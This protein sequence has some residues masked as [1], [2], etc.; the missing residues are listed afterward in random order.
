MESALFKRGDVTETLTVQTAQMKKAVVRTL[1]IDSCVTWLRRR[2]V[3]GIAKLSLVNRADRGA[4]AG[5]DGLEGPKTPRPKHWRHGRC[6]ER[7]EGVHVP[8]QLGGAL[9]NVVSS[10]AGSWWSYPG[11]AENIFVVA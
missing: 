7:E 10:P 2:L 11:P 9:G 4:Y 3:G 8:S 5:F 1:V 6:E